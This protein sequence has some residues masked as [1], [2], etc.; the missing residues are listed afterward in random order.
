MLLPTLALLLAGTVSAD[1]KDTAKKDIQGAWTVQS[2]MEQGMP[3]PD[4]KTKNAKF[5]ISAD[6]IVVKAQDREE[7][8]DYKADASKKPATIDIMP[9]RGGNNR[10]IKGIYQ[11]EGDTLKICFRKE[12]ERPTE[13]SSTAENKATLVVLK[14][15]K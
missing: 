2:L 14:R 4:D 6:K 1:A 3:A 8:A 10:T 11:L 5:T 12:G 9:S 15:D 13:F 7:P